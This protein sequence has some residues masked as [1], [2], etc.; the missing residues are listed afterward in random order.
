MING[1]VGRLYGMAVVV[2]TTVPADEAM[3]YHRDHCAWAM[4]QAPKFERDRD[5]KGLKDEYA[6]S[7]QYG[8]KVLRSG[9]Y[10]VRL[11]VTGA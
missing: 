10:G 9:I 7:M 2:S 8:V 11:N 1:E 4:Q 6:L 5:I 3:V